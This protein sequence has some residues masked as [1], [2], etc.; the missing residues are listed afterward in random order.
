MVR[1]FWQIFFPPTGSDNCGCKAGKLS[2]NP[3]L[4]RGCRATCGWQSNQLVE[5]Q[6]RTLWTSLGGPYMFTS[7]LFPPPLSTLHALGGLN[8]GKQ[9]RKSAA[10]GKG[11]HT[12]VTLGK[13]SPPSDS[14][15][16][17]S[18]FKPRR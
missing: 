6:F 9:T 11:F 16:L 10:T 17:A 15:T 4:S 14:P 8:K 2:A 3:D 1:L 13:S 12:L 7:F 18:L 5:K